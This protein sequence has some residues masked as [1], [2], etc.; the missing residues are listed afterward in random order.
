MHQSLNPERITGGPSTFSWSITA[1][2]SYD[3]VKEMIVS[4]PALAL[5]N[6]ELHSIMT[7]DASDY[8]LGAVLT[9]I[10]VDKME[11]TITFTS[12]TL[13]ESQRKYSTEEKEALGCVWV[14]EKWRTY[15]WGRHFT[16]RTDHSPLTTQ[17]STK[18]LGRA[19]M[20]VAR[21]S[22]RLLSFY[23]DIQDKLGSENLTA[24]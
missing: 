5:L 15:L 14:T 20:R 8:G 6:P 11:K 3:S 18:R 12:R 9:Q 21:W 17:L 1:Q 4:N 7:S 23:Y 19:G 13:T 2:Q 22:A 24:D 16:L 10:H